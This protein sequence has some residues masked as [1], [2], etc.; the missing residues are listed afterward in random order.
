[1]NLSKAIK[2]YKV[3]EG[4]KISR[5]GN[6]G[7]YVTSRNG[8]NLVVTDG[9]RE[10][11]Y[12]PSVEEVGASDWVRFRGELPK[13]IYV[14]HKESD[15]MKRIEIVTDDGHAYADL[16]QVIA[17]YIEARYGEVSE[18]LEEGAVMEDE[19]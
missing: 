5:S 6:E 1:M 13:R 11:L 10:L 18:I 3:S 17:D 8:E 16:V 15:G 7:S 4:G 2:A 9:I 14:S 19:S 12:T